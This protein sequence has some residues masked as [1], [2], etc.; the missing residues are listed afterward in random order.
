M[1]EAESE[2]IRVKLVGYSGALMVVASTWRQECAA[3]VVIFWGVGKR[4]LGLVVGDCAGAFVKININA[5]ESFLR[6]RTGRERN[7]TWRVGEKY[8][9]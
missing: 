7:R 8:G 3:D 9:K 6:T 2:G 5:G 1:K 4:M